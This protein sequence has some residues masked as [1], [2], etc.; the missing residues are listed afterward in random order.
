[1]L[2]W[3]KDYLACL[4]SVSGSLSDGGGV[5]VVTKV[6]SVEGEVRSERE[7][8]KKNGWDGERR[9]VR[10][11]PPPPLSHISFHFSHTPQAYLTTRKGGKKFAA[12]ELTLS[13]DWA[14]TG[15]GGG[16]GG[17]EDNPPPSSSGTLKVSEVSVSSDADDVLFEAGGGAPPGVASAVVKALKPGILA[18]LEA[19]GAALNE[20]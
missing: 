17:G 11:S 4:T 20:L 10:T 18:A 16:G 2:P 3:T 7:R 14:V 1:M 12:F 8:E 13:L 9:K 19:Y 6:A 5:V 15:G